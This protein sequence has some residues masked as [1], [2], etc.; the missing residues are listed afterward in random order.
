MVQSKYVP[1]KYIQV[2]M[3]C[4][5]LNE[6]MFECFMCVCEQAPSEMSHLHSFRTIYKANNYSAQHVEMFMVSH[7]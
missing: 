3:G 7:Y 2:S 6:W 5:Y 1:V 4:T